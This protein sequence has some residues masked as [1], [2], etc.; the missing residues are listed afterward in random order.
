[1]SKKKANAGNSRGDGSADTRHDEN[2]PLYVIVWGSM[3]PS[4]SREAKEIERIMREAEFV[5]VNE[6]STVMPRDRKLR[7]CGA[8]RWVSVHHEYM[9]LKRLGYDV[10]VHERASY[11]LDYDGA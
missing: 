6:L 5:E 10:S 7:V 3:V 4:G 2:A 1:M 9:E 11:A 8:S